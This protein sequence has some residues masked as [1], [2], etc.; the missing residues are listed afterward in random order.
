MAKTDI[1]LNSVI[2]FYMMLATVPATTSLS[3]EDFPASEE[4][5]SEIGRRGEPF[6]SCSDNFSSVVPLF[7]VGVLLVFYFIFFLRSTPRISSSRIFLFLLFSP[8]SLLLL[9][10]LSSTIFSVY[11]INIRDNLLLQFKK[12]KIQLTSM[13]VSLDYLVINI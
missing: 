8:M 2:H 4:A 9:L 12:K 10:F 11:C 6:Y 13:S 5:S 3:G 7:R 1:R